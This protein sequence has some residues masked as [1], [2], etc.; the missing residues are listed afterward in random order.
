MFARVDMTI[1][2]GVSDE[3]SASPVRTKVQLDTRSLDRMQYLRYD[4]NVED[5]KVVRALQAVSPDLLDQR[6]EDLAM[7]SSLICAPARLTVLS[8]HGSR[9]ANG[10]WGFRDRPGIDRAQPADAVA[11]M[12]IQSRVL[13]VAACDSRPKLWQPYL[14]PS[15]VAFVSTGKVTYGAVRQ[16]L[17]IFLPYVMSSEFEIATFPQIVE[18]WE[19]SMGRALKVA[20]TLSRP[21]FGLMT[22]DGLTRTT[23]AK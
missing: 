10:L 8:S 14:G 5:E 23:E 12:K 20:S 17:T 9:D 1:S 4:R 2:V 21:Q 11:G 22:A 7:V 19:V 13:I 3:E 18:A 6:C 15:T 16:M